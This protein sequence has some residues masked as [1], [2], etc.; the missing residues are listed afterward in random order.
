MLK[1]LRDFPTPHHDA[2]L[3]LTGKGTEE[4]R[5]KLWPIFTDTEDEPEWNIS[6]LGIPTARTEQRDFRAQGHFNT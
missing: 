3:R 6:G 4:K 2:L 1:I 5:N